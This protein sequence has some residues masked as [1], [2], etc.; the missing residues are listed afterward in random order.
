VLQR[1]HQHVM[2]TGDTGAVAQV[3]GPHDA[4]VA[5]RQAAVAA[6]AVDGGAWCAG[7]PD[8]AYGGD[9]LELVTGVGQHQNHPAT[10]SGQPNDGGQELFE[11]PAQVTVRGQAGRDL[12]QQPRRS[13]CG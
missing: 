8:R 10:R 2:R 12:G 6:I 13:H 7:F 1:Q 4:A 5:D 9:P 11:Q 3:V